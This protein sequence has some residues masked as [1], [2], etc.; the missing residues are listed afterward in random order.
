MSTRPSSLPELSPGRNNQQAAFTILDAQSTQAIPVSSQV[1]ITKQ[2]DHGD[3]TSRYMQKAEMYVQKNREYI[4]THDIESREERK[5]LALARKR[6]TVDQASQ[7]SG[8]ETIKEV[9]ALNL[10]ERRE[11][12][13]LERMMATRR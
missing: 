10:V 2:A 3:A 9:R 13:L 12:D 7:K 11:K 4:R 8:L 6:N 1:S 5:R